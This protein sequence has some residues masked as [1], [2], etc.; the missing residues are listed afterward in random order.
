MP[1]H[2]EAEM[3]NDELS[4]NMAKIAEGYK[5]LAAKYV[6]ATEDLDLGTT[7]LDM[8]KSWVDVAAKALEK[9]EELQ[10]KQARSRRLI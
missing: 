8:Y 10:K 1:K 7:W 9:P 3:R 5:Q 4:E 2:K 6:E